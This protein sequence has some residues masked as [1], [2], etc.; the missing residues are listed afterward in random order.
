M[1]LEKY[2][3]Y[4][5]EIYQ[6]FL[7]FIEDEEEENF[8]NCYEDIK[9]IEVFQGDKIRDEMISMLHLILR[10]SN[11]YHRTPNF[12]KKIE[13]I[14]LIIFND[15][16]NTL[17][18]FEIFEIFKSNKRILLFLIHN[19]I[20]TIDQIVLNFILDHDSYCHFFYPEIKSQMNEEERKI[21]EEKLLE[22]DQNIFDTFDQKRQNGENDFY[23]CS[24][25][26]DDLVE[27]FIQYV[28]QK[29]IS[30]SSHLNTSI[31]ET[32][33]FLLKNEPTLIEYSAFYGSI[34]IFNFL[35][36]NNVELSEKLWL[37]AIHS[38]N[39]IL[40]HI[41]EECNIEPYGKTYESVFIESIKC[42]HNNIAVYIQDNLLIKKEEEIKCNELIT[43]NVL[44]Y[45]PD[46]FNG[47][48]IFFN[49]CKYKHYLIVD[50]LLE[51][52]KL[53]VGY[54]MI[55]NEKKF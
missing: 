22:I 15:I 8:T 10:I 53:S 41:L 9:K 19:K 14:L 47:K 40:I 55:L 36:M 29:T 12:D 17:S 1:D 33:S 25:I 44:H 18:N 54:R 2:I 34:Q 5:K 49:L 13:Q 7:N 28:N 38:Q 51:N 3:N 37:Y 31:F 52:A 35:R 20:I 46:N 23:I 32:N 30:L 11:N 39:A 6:H 42:H 50:F 16:K 26:R 48:M 43:L 21:E 24:L 45:F 4:K 27:E